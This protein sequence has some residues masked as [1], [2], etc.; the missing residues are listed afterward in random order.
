MQNTKLYY[1]A[2]FHPEVDGG[3]SVSVP[4][5]EQ[6][7]CVC[8]TQGDTFE[9]ALQMAEQAIELALESVPRSQFPIPSLP[10]ALSLQDHESIVM[11]PHNV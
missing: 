10:T 6:I 2:I 5:M 1:P 4:D 8:C 9:E 11:V 7:N 3:Y